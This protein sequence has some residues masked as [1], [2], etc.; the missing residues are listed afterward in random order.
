MLGLLSFSLLYFLVVNAL[1]VF[2][3]RS[4]KNI[5][6]IMQLPFVLLAYVL[7]SLI[8]IPWLL[9]NYECDYRSAGLLTFIL[10]LSLIV[11][12]VFFIFGYKRKAHEV[13]NSIN[14]KRYPAIYYIRLLAAFAVFLLVFSYYKMGFVPAFTQSPFEAK[15]FA[16]KYYETYK[17]IAHYFRLGMVLAPIAIFYLLGFY[18]SEKR[19]IDLILS[20]CLFLLI[21]LSLRRGPIATPLL[22]LF[23]S[24]GAIRKKKKYLFFYAIYVFIYFFGAAFNAVFSSI[25]FGQDIKLMSFVEGVPDIMDLFVFL[26]NWVQDEWAFT[27]GKSIYGGLIPY[28]YTYNI[29]HLTKIVIAGSDQIASGGLRLPIP[30]LGYISFG[31]YG[32]VLFSAV[33]GFL[34][35]ILLKNMKI[36]L[37]R[38]TGFTTFIV[39]LFYYKNCLHL[40]ESLF[41]M[42][43]DVILMSLFVIFFTKRYFFN[44]QAQVV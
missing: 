32:V 28:H 5:I 27:Y 8:Y 6:F 42:N 9:K 33:H 3:W 25:M 39:F 15:F 19:N 1:P 36:V 30:I 13:N 38:V 41:N 21:F 24:Y 12:M 44:V 40:I 18:L 22:I 31:Y 34:L 37:T 26:Q 16:G 4:S 14:I 7:G 17:P 20:F 43:L 11:T 10:M 2:I 35:G 29:S 23:L